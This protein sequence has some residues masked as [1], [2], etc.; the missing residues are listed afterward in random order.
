MLPRHEVP[1]FSSCFSSVF[2]T[3]GCSSDC[4]DDYYRSKIMQDQEVKSFLDSH[5][6]FFACNIA[7]GWMHGPGDLG[8]TSA[9]QTVIDFCQVS[10]DQKTKKKKKH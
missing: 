5:P 7:P 1:I 9:G 10:R 3:F 8:P 6:D 2:L 4:P